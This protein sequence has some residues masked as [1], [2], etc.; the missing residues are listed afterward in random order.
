MSKLKEFIKKNQ[1]KVLMVLLVLI[2]MFQVGIR[3][4]YGNYKAYL[5]MDE[6]YSYGLMNY[7]KVDL[8][9]NE[10]F[11]NTW[12]TSDY[13]MD[14]L[15]I[16]SEESTD[17]TPVYENQKNDVHPPF[18]Y[19]L[20]RIASSF[21]IDSFSKWTGIILNIIIF[22]IS[23]IFVYLIANK[24]FKNKIYALF[25]VLVNGCTLAS[26]DTTVFIRMYALGTLNLLI[27]S[28]LHIINF[29]KSD[30][31]FKDLA[32]M[33]IFI[34]IGS[35]THYY[36]L[37]FLFVLFVIYIVK[38]IKEKNVKNIIKYIATMVISAA[39]SLAIFPY[40]FVH[41]FMGY[42]GTGAIS[43]LTNLEQMWNSLGKYLGILNHNVF[44]GVLI[45]IVI[46]GIVI[47]IYK[48]AKN[49]KITLRFNNK[50]FWLIFIPTVIYFI[51]VAL[52]SP[53]QELRYV[54]PVC[55]LLII[56]VFYLAKILFEKVFNQKV[57]YII[58]TVT[59]VVM[60]ILPDIISALPLGYEI[61]FYYLYKDKKEIVETIEEEHNVPCLYVF[62]TSQ[63]RFLDDLYLFTI[64]DNSYV[65][66]VNEF[67][68]EKVTEI[69]ENI[70]L[71]NGLIVFINGGLENDTYLNELV[72]TLNLNNIQYVQ[73][74]NACD[75]YK[76]N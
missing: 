44:N 61:N 26:I 20:L 23:S 30:L 63:N 24:L 56:T 13:Y 57:T 52:I 60:L 49:K 38:F 73:R 76:I 1:N 17:F 69:F 46:A 58:L 50:E 66:D 71:E 42:R 74:M 53:Y 40:S 37:L 48:I 59:F 54:M 72:E 75:I 6:G 27:I 8:M 9:A 55:P 35:L 22:V 43:T 34:I 47:A 64:L 62:N 2:I 15:S 4:Q 67:S 33:S 41:M 70:D 36:Y 19:L 12:H 31:K 51:I 11:Y 18:Y 45:F 65:M 25:I 16:S 7:D 39:I 29:N 3:I 14:Y 5:H 21:T 68:E 28:Y 10:D 32:I